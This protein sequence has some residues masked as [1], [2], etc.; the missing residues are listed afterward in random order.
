[1]LDFMIRNLRKFVLH[2]MKHILMNKLK[3][4]P[5]QIFVLFCTAAIM[6]LASCSHNPLDVDVSNIHIPPVKI[7]RME[8][9]MFSMNPDSINEYTPVMLKKYGPFYSN[10]V[11]SFINDAGIRD[12]TYAASLKRFITDKDMRHAYDSCEKDYPDMSFLE[13]SLTNAFKHYKYYFPDSAL[14]RVVTVMTGFNYAM[15]YYNKTL[16][17]ALERYL[18]A[19]NA[20]YD[21]LQ[22]PMY[23][24]V[25]MSKDY[26]LCDAVYGWLESIFKPNE[27][28][29]DMLS[30][31]VHEGKIMYMEDALLPKVNDTLKI[32][33][34]AKQLQW[35]KENEFNM[36]AY[37]IQQKMLYS[38]D[39]VEI[40]KF[41]NDGPFTP[42]FNKDFCPARTGNWIGWR[43]VRSYMKNNPDVTIPQLMAQKSAD[44]ILQRSGYKPSK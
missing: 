42:M 43:I 15:I 9:D 41:T 19:K 2:L 11:I 30:Q 17:I 1:M 44:Y 27:D 13:N 3:F 34:T 8:K 28:K 5:E 37:I 36:W 21:M 33:Y 4:K 25:R 14:P 12:S 26:M 40:A 39:Q 16:A 6:L 10:L 20:F 18:G 22:Y 7:D 31:I 23:K 29:N 32:Q 24:K 38:T 35:C